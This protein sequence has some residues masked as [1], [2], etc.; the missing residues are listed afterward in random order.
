MRSRCVPLHVV[1]AAIAWG[2]C[3]KGRQGA[4]VYALG[5]REI[6]DLNP[7]EGLDLPP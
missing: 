7:Q 1:E 6:G 3:L 2:R 5:R 4:R